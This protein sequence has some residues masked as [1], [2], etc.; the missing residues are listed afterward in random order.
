MTWLKKIVSAPSKLVKYSSDK[1]A[2]LDDTVRNT[3]NKIG[4][5]I[6]SVPKAVGS[7]GGDLFS[8]FFKSAGINPVRLGAMVVVGF[9]AYKLVTK[10]TNGSSV[11]DST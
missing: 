1:L 4:D 7:A 10:K 2:S 8:S 3:T 11:E 6:A 5:K 9:A